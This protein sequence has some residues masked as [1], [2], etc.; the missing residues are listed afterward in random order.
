LKPFL[1]TIAFEHL[2]LFRRLAMQKAVKRV[3]VVAATGGV[4]IVN[5]KRLW[6]FSGLQKSTFRPA[7]SRKENIHVYYA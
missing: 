4:N 3:G 7:F 5:V 1:N 6:K 2:R